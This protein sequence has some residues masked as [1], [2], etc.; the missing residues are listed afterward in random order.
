LV[1]RRLRDCFRPVAGSIV[2]IIQFGF[3]NREPLHD[4]V[5][6]SLR[7]DGEQ[8]LE[9]D[10]ELDMHVADG[11]RHD[12][13]QNPAFDR[14]AI[15]LCPPQKRRQ[16]FRPDD[17]E[18]GSS[19]FICEAKLNRCISSPR[20][21]IRAR[22]CAPPHSCRRGRLILYRDGCSCPNAKEGRSVPS[23][24]DR[25]WH[26]RSPLFQAFGVALGHKLNKIS[27]WRSS[28]SASSVRP[29]AAGNT[30]VFFISERALPRQKPLLRASADLSSRNHRSIR[31]CI[32]FGAASPE[33]STRS[34]EG[35][36]ESTR[37]LHPRSGASWMPTAI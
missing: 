30:S 3:W 35:P 1:F 11:D 26:G 2:E 8:V 9:G 31:I 5:R 20:S 29:I 25:S 33:R 21:P 16:P 34:F 28:V 19:R 17:P 37:W 23:D 36:G 22:C 13:S 7:V 27:D 10:I 12:H 24:G 32:V 6:A 18:L 15:H 14:V 4:L